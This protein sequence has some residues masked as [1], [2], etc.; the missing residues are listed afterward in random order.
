MLA[1]VKLAGK[2]FVVSPEK[3][4]KID[5]GL[6]PKEKK[7][8]ISEV[9][10]FS[11]DKILKIGKPVIENISVEMEIIEVKKSKKVLVVKHHSKK[12]YRRTKGHRQDQTFLR[13]VNIGTEKLKTLEKEIKPKKEKNV[14]EK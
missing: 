8:I 2:Q 11:D 10:L 7:L 4:I 13:V 14:K 12:R 3:S 5:A 1:V 9:L 6:D